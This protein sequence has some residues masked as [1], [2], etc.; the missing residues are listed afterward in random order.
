MF[1]FTIVNLDS[2]RIESKYDNIAAFI[3]YEIDG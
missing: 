1:F 2:V 3:T